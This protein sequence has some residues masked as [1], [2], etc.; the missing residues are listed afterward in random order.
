M[1]EPNLS[2]MSFF[3]EEELRLLF[4]EAGAEKISKT[5]IRALQEELADI[6]YSIIKLATKTLT[7]DDTLGANHLVRAANQFS[8]MNLPV[9]H[10]IW[11]INS[12]G[13][14]LFSKSYSGLK[15]PDTIFSGLLLGITNMCEEVSGRSLERLVLG[16]MSIHLRTVDPILIAIV[17]DN[18][19]D[20]VSMIVN[21]LGQRFI[22][23]FGHRL[24]ETAVDINVFTP[25]EHSV[26][27]IIRGWGIALPDQV[28]GEGVQKLLEPE[29]IKESVFRAAQRKDI[30]IA[31]ESLKSLP[32]FSRD[33]SEMEDDLDRIVRM[34]ERSKDPNRKTGV[35]FIKD[36]F[37]N[38]DELKKAMQEAKDQE[39]EDEEE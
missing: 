2:N 32:L 13:T 33:E 17:S 20:A 26:R 36:I 6:G 10:N 28:T 35:D 1:N 29:L 38:S 39:K 21:Q 4:I 22:E 31:F 30:E 9:I 24:D 19:G 8:T 27:D 37:T 23:I 16:D 3:K 5:A 15:F 12:N 11:I 18:I 7:D 14:C 25:F 34:R